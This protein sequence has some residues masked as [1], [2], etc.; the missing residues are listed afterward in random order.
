VSISVF[1]QANIAKDV[2]EQANATK[3]VDGLTNINKDIDE[4]QFAYYDVP[5]PVYCPQNNTNLPNVY[6]TYCVNR[7]TVNHE[8]ENEVTSGV[9]DELSDSEGLSQCS[10]VHV[11]LSYYSLFHRRLS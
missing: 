7:P 10:L 3:D 8:Q 5:R 11:R 2:D 4:H 1:R 9:G 6:T